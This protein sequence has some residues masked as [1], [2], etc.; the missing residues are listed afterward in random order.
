M[1]AGC[2]IVGETGDGSAVVATVQSLKPDVVLLDLQL[3][4]MHG[5]EITRQL[6]VAAPETRVVVLTMHANEAY[7]LEAVRGGAYGYVLK[8]AAGSAL[9]E[10]VHQAAAGRHY[11]SPPLSD[12]VIEAYAKRATAGSVDSYETLSHREREVLRLAAQGQ[13]NMEIATTLHISSRTVE[14]HR[15][16]VMAKLGFDRQTDLVYYAIRKGIVT[17]DH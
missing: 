2:R 4:G 12:V 13:S 14:A 11:L 10:A 8:E 7:V 1:D 9:V 17:I 3:P 5:L 16:K 15:A 6:K